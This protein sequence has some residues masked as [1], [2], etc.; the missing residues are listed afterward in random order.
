MLSFYLNKARKGKGVQDFSDDESVIDLACLVN[1]KDELCDDESHFSDFEEFY[2]IA[3]K[4]EFPDY[5][6]FSLELEEFTNKGL[7]I[8]G[9]ENAKRKEP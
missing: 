8:V 4:D 1:S 7:W 9:E 3:I 5:D 6:V 2:L